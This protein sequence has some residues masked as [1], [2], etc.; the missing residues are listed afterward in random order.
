MHHQ[1]KLDVFLIKGYQ[2]ISNGEVLELPE[3]LNS[4]ISP[5]QQ[6]PISLKP[7]DERHMQYF[8]S[9]SQLYDA[10]VTIVPLDE[11]SLSLIHI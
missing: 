9:L 7:L 3:L 6:S 10:L 2:L 11:Q 8:Q 1:I 5:N 4:T